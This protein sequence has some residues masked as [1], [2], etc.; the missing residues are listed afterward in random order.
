MKF[1]TPLIFVLTFVI[2]YSVVAQDT[3]IFKSNLGAGLFVDRAGKK[4]KFKY[5]IK[6][7]QDIPAA[8]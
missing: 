7:S 2:S 8:K 3:L 4:L 5:L 6:S 1:I